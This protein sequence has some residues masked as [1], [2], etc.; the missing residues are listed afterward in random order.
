[1]TNL[2]ITPAAA[3]A[4]LGS[5]VEYH[6]IAIYSDNSTQDVSQQ[7]AWSINN[8]QLATIEQGIVHTS[9]IGEVT[10]Q[11]HLNE[12]SSNL[13]KLSIT[14]AKLTRLVL[15]PM[16]STVANGSDIHY[17][18]MGFY[19]DGSSKDLSHSAH[20]Q[21]SSPNL[22]VFADNEAHTLN[23]GQAEIS[24]H[25]N[26][27]SSNTAKLNISEA[28]VTELQ[29]TPANL[30]LANGTDAQYQAIARYSDGT[31][32]VITE[33]IN[34]KTSD[35]NIATIDANGEAHALAQ[36]Q[37]H[38]TANYQD[39]NS[40]TALLNITAAKLT[41]LQITP[42]IN[43]IPNGTDIKLHAIAT[44][45]DNTTQEVSHA[46]T[47]KASNNQLATINQGLVHALQQGPVQ[48][49]AHI[50]EIS[51]N[52][53]TVNITDATL[54]SLQL[55]PSQSTIANGNQQHYQVIGHY[56]D[57]S[58]KDLSHEANISSSNA[59]VAVIVNA[60]AETSAPGTSLIT[61]ELNGIKSNQ[62]ELTVTAATITAIQVTPTTTQIA[63]GSELQ[64]HA[65]AS[66]TDGTTQDISD[67]VDWRSSQVNIATI[68]QGLAHAD[69]Q[70][71]T[72]ISASHNGIN[73]N[74]ATLNVTEAIITAIQVTPAVSS[75]ALGFEQQYTA[76]ATY[77]DNSV[78]NITTQ[79]DWSSSQTT[80]ATIVNGL[81]A[82]N[83]IGNINVIA[84]YQGINSNTAQLS[85]TDKKVVQL[86]LTP[87]NI[88]LALGTSMPIHV[89]ASYSDGT[90]AEVTDKVSWQLTNNSVVAIDGSAQTVSAVNQG[91]TNIQAHWQADNINSNL[92]TA[93]V[94]AATLSQILLNPDEITIKVGSHTTIS[95]YGLYSDDSY[96]SITEQV[97]WISS[98]TNIAT[99]LKGELDGIN[100]GEITV[101]ATMD[102][103]SAQAKVMVEEDKL[104]ALRIEPAQAD[105]PIGTDLQL[106]VIGIYQS[107]TEQDIGSSND[108][109]WSSNSN[110]LTIDATG[111]AY[112]VNQQNGITVT[113]RKDQLSQT[114][115]INVTDAVVKKV[116]V[117]QEFD[118]LNTVFTATS[119]RQL[120]AI[121]TMTDNTKIDVT[122]SAAWQESTSSTK[123]T[124]VKGL[125][126]TSHSGG[127]EITAIYRGISSAPFTVTIIAP[128][129]R[130]CSSNK[131]TIP[132]AGG[133]RTFTCPLT[134]T[135]Y[136]K[137]TPRR[138]GNGTTSPRGMLIPMANYWEASN[139]CKARNMR[140]PTV[141][142]LRALHNAA[143]VVSSLD[144]Q[145]YTRF[146][147]PIEVS[148][149]TNEKVDRFHHRI[150]NMVGGAKHSKKNKF[151]YYWTCVK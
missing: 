91:Q 143:D 63:K 139:N 3:Q 124:V 135:E 101:S 44:Y 43:T 84:S 24:A 151:D 79:A 46:V 82:T 83:N 54:I 128:S 50:D 18:I 31:T 40:N 88:E 120:K 12:Y 142:E 131:I 137:S 126:T 85:I 8:N 140:L 116:E 73:S 109:Q 56:S 49:S 102:N 149:W 130:S 68:N 5:D 129:N 108:I 39:I 100:I 87:T 27:I 35:T 147:W 113:V 7:V 6:V 30:Q 114:K 144:Y 41:S 86:Q 25:L 65:L 72:Q 133:T 117:K 4:A 14:D 13:A 127:S 59:N 9:A 17:Q 60:K 119:K 51:S 78:Q 121:A 55:T 33:S 52:I 134:T 37:T 104:T 141:N 21:S 19:S 94:S 99:V 47:W 75:I 20:L 106:K 64:Y 115:Q 22:V 111:V 136:G 146:G 93:N 67:K 36:G 138:A 118:H 28:K 103:I 107:G 29:I 69:Q 61:A 53:A 38:V 122:R 76:I 80:I 145:V 23:K 32:Q 77:S 42:A 66:Y 105:I 34:W 74:T 150:V 89:Q 132:Y 112:G 16:N 10:I 90:S 45:S 92:I 148:Y 125:V 97:D 96:Q 26:G 110:N 81:A 2:Q 70:G 123:A 15:S 1:M 58:T 71:Q 57:H 48:F 95:A 98:N 62:A 11:A